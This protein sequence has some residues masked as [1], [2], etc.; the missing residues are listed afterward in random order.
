MGKKTV[1]KYIKIYIKRLKED[2]K[3]EKVI[4]YGSYLTDQFN[5]E[6]D[7]DLLII[8]KKFQKLD[9]DERLKILYRKTIGLP[10]DLHIYG[11]T[12]DEIKNVSPLKTLYTA[13]KNGVEIS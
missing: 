7:I 1:E 4:L 6:S 5:K 12:P 13:L 2:I 9:D 10:L 11:L 8:S 3:P